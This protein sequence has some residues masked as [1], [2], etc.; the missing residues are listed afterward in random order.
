MD[1]ST[2]NE[3]RLVAATCQLC[4]ESRNAR[5]SDYISS[6]VA[7]SQRF[8]CRVRFKLMPRSRVMQRSLPC[9]HFAR[10]WVGVGATLV[11]RLAP[12]P[13]FSRKQGKEPYRG[14]V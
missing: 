3:R 2:N 13:T 7:V 8:L 9:A 5:R 1:A 4:L 14:D 12:I 6:P 10:G 11:P